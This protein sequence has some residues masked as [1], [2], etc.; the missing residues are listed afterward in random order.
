MFDTETK[1][2]HIPNRK[3]SK[4]KPKEEVQMANKTKIIE[5]S[6]LSTE[7]HGHGTRVETKKA[8]F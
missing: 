1:R 3:L 5:Y 7:D 6:Y 2:A 8:F 4:I